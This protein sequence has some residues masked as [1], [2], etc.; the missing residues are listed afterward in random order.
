MSGSK[1]GDEE[2]ATG[3]LRA[4]EALCSRQKGEGKHRPEAGRRVTVVPKNRVPC[5]Q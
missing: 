1:D 4:E 3:K 2:V 5:G